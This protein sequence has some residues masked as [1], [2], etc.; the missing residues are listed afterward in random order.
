MR[1]TENGTISTSSVA[2]FGSHSIQCSVFSEVAGSG[3]SGRMGRAEHLTKEA[4]TIFLL[5]P[6][7]QDGLEWPGNSCRLVPR[8][9]TR[10][11]PV[12]GPALGQ[13]L[14]SGLVRLKRLGLK[15]G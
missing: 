11:F 1:L 7:L 2:G 10:V 14:K 5:V 8:T 6:N 12:R 4:V 9:N 3:S 13:Y 15:G